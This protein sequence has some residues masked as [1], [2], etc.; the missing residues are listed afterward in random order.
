MGNKNKAVWGVRFNNSTSKV[1]EKIGASIDIDKSALLERLIERASA[2]TWSSRS[3]I[4]T[5]IDGTSIIRD[6]NLTTLII[7]DGALRLPAT[8]DIGTTYWY[9]TQEFETSITGNTITGG[10]WMTASVRDTFSMQ[11]IW[12]SVF[13]IDVSV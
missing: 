2:I 11:R 12:R 5:M 3:I 7:S 10:G 9:Y 6:I 1:F 8:T 13:R 4:D